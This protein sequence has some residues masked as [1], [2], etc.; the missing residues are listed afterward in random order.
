MSRIR[1]VF[2]L[3]EDCERNIG[4][5]RSPKPLAVANYA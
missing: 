4:D 2:R 5:S 1:Q 3:A